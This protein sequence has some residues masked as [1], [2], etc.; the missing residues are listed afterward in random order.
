MNSEDLAKKYRTW[1]EIDRSAIVANY[2][3]FRGLISQKTAL[4]AVIKSNAYGH[5]IIEY[6]HELEKLGV[7]WF[8]VDSTVEAMVLRREGVTKPILALGYTLPDKFA[9][10]AKLGIHM[11][12]ST[13]EQLEEIKKAGLSEKISIHIK[14]DTGM[15]RQGFSAQG[16][17]ERLFQVLVD[18]KDMIDV[19]GLFTH[20]AA[21]KDP[22]G[23]DATKDQIQEFEVW[24]KSF[25]DAGFSPLCHAGATSGTILYPDAHYDLVRV[26]I[27]MY[28][29]W[30][31]QAVKEHAK[32]NI[33]LTPTLSWK[34]I[35]SEVKSLPK[36]SK[37][38]YD[39]TEELM[40]DSKVAICP[41]GYWH[42]FDRAFSSKAHVIVQGKRAK[43]VG[44]VSMG[45]IVID[46]TDI[47][48]V[49]VGDVV[50]LL[51]KD[52]DGRVTAEELAQIAGTINY[53]IVTGINPRIVR[54]VM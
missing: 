13:F 18:M 45:M 21:A 6:A 54:M 37:V 3:T 38:G 7:D 46:V 22:H 51:G 41:V 26:G 53:D 9:D 5:G 30:P 20:F 8:G 28:G 17:M 16:G 1:V 42:G 43:I 29:L 25:F 39:F 36:G 4:M 34:T 11:S 10:V 49:R 14:V 19:A 50:T 33:V 32:K 24:R 12:V 2:K 52:G 15:H 44:R 27:G 31:A 48:D 35:I 40:R 47:E 23:P